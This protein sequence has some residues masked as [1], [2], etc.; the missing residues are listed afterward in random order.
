MC[1]SWWAISEPGPPQEL[2]VDLLDGRV[3]VRLAELLAA[4]DRIQRRGPL[5]EQFG[6]EHVE[7]F[8]RIGLAAAA[9]AAAGAGHDLDHVERLLA[10][11]DLVE[12]HLGVGQAVGHADVDVVLADGHVGLAEPFHGADLGEFQ[13]VGRLAGDQLGGGAERGFHHAAGGAEDVAGAAGH[14]QR[15][16]ELAR[17]AAC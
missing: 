11:L 3:L 16:V 1:S 2:V 9:D 15:G 6:I 10:G 5:A 7:A 8:G 14:A 4:V 12:Q 17:R 13:P